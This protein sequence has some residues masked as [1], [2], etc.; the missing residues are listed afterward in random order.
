MESEKV[1]E[2]KKALEDLDM[3]CYEKAC[4]DRINKISKYINELEKEK[5]RLDMV[6]KHN[7]ELI[8][9]GKLISV[10]RLK[11]FA[12]RLKEHPIMKIYSLH[13]ACERIPNAIDETLKD[14]LGERK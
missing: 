12:E 3:I 13:N 10:E 2:I 1:K 11:Q 8:E 14:F 7:Q 5:A 6:V 9:D 4:S